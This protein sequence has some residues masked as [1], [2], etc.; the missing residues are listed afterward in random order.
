VPKAFIERNGFLDGSQ[1][2]LRFTENTMTVEAPQKPRYR[3]AELMAEMAE[4][5][6]GSPR[7]AGWDV[8][9]AVGLEQR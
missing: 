6:E 7:V 3:L 1:V 4:V 2:E 9:P 8:L 5:A